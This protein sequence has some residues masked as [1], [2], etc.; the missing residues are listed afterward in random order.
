MY[1]INVSACIVT[2]L[3]LTLWNPKDYSLPDSNVNMMMYNLIY[4]KEILNTLK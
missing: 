3:C 1:N 4:F 2:Q